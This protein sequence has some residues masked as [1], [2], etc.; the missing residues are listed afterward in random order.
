[1]IATYYSADNYVEDATFTTTT[2]VFISSPEPLLKMALRIFHPVVERSNTDSQPR[3]E[4]EAEIPGVA[5][6]GL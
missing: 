5:P 2:I 4:S 6:G 1:L 3:H